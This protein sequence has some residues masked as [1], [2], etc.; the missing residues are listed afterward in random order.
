M[1]RTGI[2]ISIIFVSTALVAYSSTSSQYS[3]KDSFNNK[4]KHNTSSGY[5]NYP[6]WKLRYIK[7][8]FLYAK[9]MEFRVCP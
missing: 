7:G 2:F 6:F 5:Q 8:F 9:S 4:L 3:K 1:S